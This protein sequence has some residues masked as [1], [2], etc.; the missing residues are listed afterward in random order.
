MIGA[1]RGE[2]LVEVVVAILLLAIGALALV[3]GLAYGERA[4][5]RAIGEALALSAA[6][7][8]MEAWRAS[9]AGP[10]SRAAS[11]PL[12]WGARSGRLD[13]LTRPIGSCREEAVVHARSESGTG[14]T[15]A[16]RRFAGA[17]CA[18]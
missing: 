12:A 1:D 7:S 15:L 16:S 2:T 11:E 18:E 8:W 9:P 5:G 14:V 17:A 6:V 10:A 13:W 4:R 3:G